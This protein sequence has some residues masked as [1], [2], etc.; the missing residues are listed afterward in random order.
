MKIDVK[1]SETNQN[2]YPQFGEV[3]NISD[4]GYERGY[5]EGNEK[6]YA[7]GHEAGY[8]EGYSAGI[9]TCSPSS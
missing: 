4:G 2:F 1:F 3:Y 8:D 5:D 7:I 6:G 9:V